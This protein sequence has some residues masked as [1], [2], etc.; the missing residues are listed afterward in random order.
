MTI[1]PALRRRARERPPTGLRRYW[2]EI[3]FVLVVKTIAM[4]VIWYAWFAGPSR[5]G[6]SADRVGERLY[7]SAAPATQQ[8]AAHAR[9]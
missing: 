8:G 6:V 9:P 4:A 3:A 5:N 1:E 7:T 2:R